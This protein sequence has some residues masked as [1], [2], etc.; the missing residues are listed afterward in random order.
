M[1]PDT[2]SLI[3]EHRSAKGDV[4]AVARI[5]GILAAKNTCR[6][7]PLCHPINISSVEVGFKFWGEETGDQGMSGM[8]V[9]VTVKSLGTSGLEM[10]ALCAVST[11]GLTIY[12]M[13]KKVDRG[14]RIE[15]VRV[16]FKSGGHAGDWTEQGWS[17]LSPSI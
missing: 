1:H 8:D 6:T 12:D 15:G 9:E 17:K 10:E 7:I 2:Y 13:C 4:I 14:M 3:K 16:V 5:A 11:A